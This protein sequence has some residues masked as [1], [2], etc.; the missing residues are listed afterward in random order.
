MALIRAISGSSGGG[1]V[2]E[3]AE[4]HRDGSYRYGSLIKDNGG[5]LTGMQITSLTTQ[6]I[7]TGNYLE[8]NVTDFTIKALQ[9]SKY[10]VLSGTNGFS[11]A[12]YSAGDTIISTPTSS[13]NIV[14]PIM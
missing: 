1:G 12:Q 6:K 2:Q 7:A 3:V 8:V 10:A 14:F 5:T 4:I 9:S 11:V 13:S